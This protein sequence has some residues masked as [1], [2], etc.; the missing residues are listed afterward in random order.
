[1]C[2]KE[3]TKKCKISNYSQKSFKDRLKDIAR[4]KLKQKQNWATQ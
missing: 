4:F 1:M 2:F 3:A